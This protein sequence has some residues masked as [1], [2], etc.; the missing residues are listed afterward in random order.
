M[1]SSARSKLHG[2]TAY[3]MPAGGYWS[4]VTVG[5]AKPSADTK[6]RSSSSLLVSG[7]IVDQGH[8]L[9]MVDPQSLERKLAIRRVNDAMQGK[10][11]ESTTII[12]T[13]N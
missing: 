6:V 1:T 7:Q 11:I 9:L 4:D 5:P 8:V 3:S 2:D 13:D 10:S 12:K